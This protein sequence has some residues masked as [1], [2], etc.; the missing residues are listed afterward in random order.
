[1]IPN[2]KDSGLDDHGAKEVEA[3]V[4]S[5]SRIRSMYSFKKFRLFF[6]VVFSCALFQSCKKDF[7]VLFE[8]AKTTYAKKDYIET[9][10]TLNQSLSVWNESH[11][12]EVR[13]QTYQMLG[14]TYEQLRNVDKAIEAYE[15]A[16]KLSNTTSTSALALGMIYQGKSQP[17]LSIPYFK[18]AIQMDPQN[19]LAYLG[20]GNSYFSLRQYQESKAAFQKTID[21]APGA[22]EALEALEI[23]KNQNNKNQTTLQIKRPKTKKRSNLEFR[24]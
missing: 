15:A 14:N 5:F 22:K 12:Q 19:S 24:H 17:Q 20:L 13:A 21:V 8:K 23:L 4:F 6:F 9:I 18:K 3:I 1:M 2:P 16:I 10:D 11:G 7:S